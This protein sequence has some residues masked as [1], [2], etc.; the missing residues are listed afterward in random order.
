[1]LSTLLVLPVFTALV[2]GRGSEGFRDHLAWFDSSRIL[3]IP[4]GGGLQVY[5]V[6]LVLGAVTTVLSLWQEVVPAL[7]RIASGSETPPGDLVRRARSLPGWE[8]CRVTMTQDDAIFVATTGR[9]SRPR[10]IVSDG[11]L[12][13]LNA[14]EQETVLLHE[15]AHWQRHR[16]LSSHLLF[17]VRLF[18]CYNPMALW[19]FREYS[20]EVEIDCDAEAVAG[21][22]PRV[23]ARAL[24]KVYESTSRRDLSARSTLRA[25]VDILL[26]KCRRENEDAAVGTVVLATLVLMV[27]LP[28]IV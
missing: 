9:P 24:L 3:L 20:I 8:R 18:Q 15:H 6:V 12:A 2:P 21:R 19:S 10:L 11:T 5:H 27:L 7:R 4:V 14:E 23:L 16:W 22:D 28:W 26:G 1:M 25:R 13:K 17:A